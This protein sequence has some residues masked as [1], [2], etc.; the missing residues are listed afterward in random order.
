MRTIQNVQELIQ[1]THK[2]D[3]LYDTMIRRNF[4]NEAL[5]VRQYLLDN[6]Y[7]IKSKAYRCPYCDFL[8]GGDDDKQFLFEKKSTHMVCYCCGEEFKTREME[9][10]TLLIRTD[11]NT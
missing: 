4:G 8:L 10:E 9:S 6:K 1:I 3:R 11:K 5:E 7:A 2:G